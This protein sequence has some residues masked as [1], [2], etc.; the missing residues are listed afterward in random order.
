MADNAFIEGM[1]VDAMYLAVAAL[2][3]TLEDVVSKIQ[4]RNT[5]AT[6]VGDG[7]L[8]TVE[9][10]TVRLKSDVVEVQELLASYTKQSA[11]WLVTPPLDP[12]LYV[13]I[14]EC[15]AIALDLKAEINTLCAD[16]R[17]RRT[18]LKDAD[19][20]TL[21]SSVDSFSDICSES[22]SVI[23]LSPQ[24][25]IAI[26]VLAL[27][28]ICSNIEEHSR[29][30]EEFLPLFKVYVLRTTNIQRLHLSNPFCVRKQRGLIN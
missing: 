6:N 10:Q 5:P 11:C 7:I 30:I 2:S 16:Q 19:E 4:E 17:D 3:S 21:I 20:W 29:Q 26:R 25:N 13:W 8:D 15:S 27:D 18:A 14:S 12:T 23:N 24:E 22:Q 1:D 9:Q 28:K